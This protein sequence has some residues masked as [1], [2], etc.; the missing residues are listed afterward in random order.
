MEC[1][2]QTSTRDCGMCLANPCLSGPTRQR[3]Y[4]CLQT[5]KCLRCVKRKGNNATPFLRE[6]RR[7][8]CPEGK[9]EQLSPCLGLR[10]SSGTPMTCRQNLDD[11]SGSDPAQRRSRF[12]PEET[13][14]RE[15]S[16]GRSTFA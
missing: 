13:Y 15:L 11:V 3:Q 4:L 6:S 8:Q 1:S 7:I 9:K 16:P 12:E 2:V 10:P 5:R 14:R